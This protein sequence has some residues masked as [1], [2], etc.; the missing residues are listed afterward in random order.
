MTS[1]TVDTLGALGEAAGARGGVM[2]VS[3]CSMQVEAAVS[4]LYASKDRQQQ[5][6]A[7]RWL[8]EFQKSLPAWQVSGVPSW[9]AHAPQQ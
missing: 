3:A 6:E 2:D 4:A 7:D 9:L 5:T 8:R 1:T